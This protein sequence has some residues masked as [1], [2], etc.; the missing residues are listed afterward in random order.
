[1]VIGQQYVITDWFRI[2]FTEN[3]G[4]AFGIELGGD[5][6]KILLTIFRILIVIFFILWF[7]SA[8]R[9]K[10]SKLLII[11]LSFIFAGAVGN[12][13][14]SVFYGV[15]FSD[16]MGQLAS[17]LPEGGGYAPIFMGHVVDMFYFPL[18]E[19][20]LPEWIP[21]WG[22]EHFIFFQPIFNIADASIS[23]GIIL[24]LIFF[25]KLN[26]V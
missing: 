20:I 21:I 9:K 5:I 13:I 2:L 8:I 12:I 11:F 16:S 24:F 15:L 1:M 22:G 7:R 25:R 17:F 10:Q 3:K 4:M 23:V 26:K 14:D 19:G 18:W 6:G